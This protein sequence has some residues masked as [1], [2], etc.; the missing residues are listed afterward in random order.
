[1]P[2]SK[3][4]RLSE[5]D[6]MLRSVRERDWQLAE[7]AAFDLDASREFLDQFSHLCETQVRP[8]IEAVATR[9]SIYGG[10]G[11]VEMRRGGD[12]LSRGPRLTMWLSLKEEIAGIRSQT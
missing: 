11:T 3:D 7:G 6:Q 2:S 10:S 4:D 9:L 5:I 12:P 8:V 1:M